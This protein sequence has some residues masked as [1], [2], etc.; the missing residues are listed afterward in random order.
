MVPVP[1]RAAAEE[2][3]VGRSSTENYINDEIGQQ[4]RFGAIYS[5]VKALFGWL[6]SKKET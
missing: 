5:F 3:P 1:R 4:I 6:T 2:T